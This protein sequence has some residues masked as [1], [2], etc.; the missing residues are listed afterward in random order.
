MAETLATAI[1]GVRMAWCVEVLLDDLE[2]KNDRNW[3]QFRALLVSLLLASFG[4]VLLVTDPLRFGVLIA[5][6][7]LY[8]VVRRGK[9]TNRLERSR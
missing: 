3:R 4:I 9:R 2:L 6:S 7:T 5:A 1:L 8:W